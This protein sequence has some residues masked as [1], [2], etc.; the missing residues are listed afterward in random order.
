MNWRE[1][2]GKA[3]QARLSANDLL[4]LRVSGLLQ[5]HQPA[6]SLT[7]S[8]PRRHHLPTASTWLAWDGPIYVTWTES[9]R[10]Q[11]LLHLRPIDEDNHGCKSRY[12][13]PIHSPLPNPSS[14][15]HPTQKYSAVR[16]FHLPLSS[17]ASAGSGILFTSNHF[18]N[19]KTTIPHTQ[20]PP[21]YRNHEVRH[22]LLRSSRP[23]GRCSHAPGQL[24]LRRR[25]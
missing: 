20:Q 23:G 8:H 15:H 4:S 19:I 22:R 7:T 25:S 2:S 9:Q 5:L 12:K 21:H 14:S 10:P 16:F 17:I 1:G 13:S 6:T 24:R 11:R 18:N 3:L